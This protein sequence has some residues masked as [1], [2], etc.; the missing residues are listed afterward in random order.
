MNPSAQ[1]VNNPIF[2]MWNEDH[3]RKHVTM[4][5]GTDSPDMDSAPVHREESGSGNSAGVIDGEGRRGL[6]GNNY[7]DEVD[8]VNFD[9]NDTKKEVMKSTSFIAKGKFS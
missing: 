8:V 6:D 5:P 2:V 9:P 3:D 7:S 1:E 4:M